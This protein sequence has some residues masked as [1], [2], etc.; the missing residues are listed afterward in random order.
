[1]WSQLTCAL[2]LCI[3]GLASLVYGSR[4]FAGQVRAPWSYFMRRPPTAPEPSSQEI[5]LTALLGFI[6]GTIAV[7]GGI[8]LFLVMLL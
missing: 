3:F 1:M 8:G 2:V 5:L 7:L 6:V 4:A